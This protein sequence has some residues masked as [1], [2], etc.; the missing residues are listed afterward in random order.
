MFR[1]IKRYYAAWRYRRAV[2]KA[3]R[4][5]ALFGMKYYVINLNGSLKVVPKRTVKELIKR[6]RFRKGVT[7]EDIERHALFVTT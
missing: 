3:R 4:L 6:R 5:A 1:I 2:R 7:V